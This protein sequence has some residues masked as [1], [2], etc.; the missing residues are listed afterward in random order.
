MPLTTDRTLSVF[1]LTALVPLSV[2]AS[3]QVPSTRAQWQLVAD[4]P[5][6]GKAA[7]F[8][9]QSFDPTT[10]RLW[11]AHM[12]A[13]EVLGFDVRT[14][15]VVARVPGMAGVTG[16]RVVPPVQRVF[17]A[18]SAG[19][20]VAILDSRDGRELARVPGGR[21]PDGLAYAPAAKKLFVSDEAGRQELV[22]DVPAARARPPIQLGG[23]A[24]NTQYDSVTG[25]IWVAVQTR[26]ELAAI[27]PL[28]DSVVE[29]IPVLGIEHP[30]GFCLDSEHRLIYVTGEENATL[31][32]LDLAEKRMLQTYPV[33]DDPDVLALDPV[34]RR[35][36][37]A[38]ESGVIAP[39]DVRGKTLVPLPQYRA[40]HAHSVG[41][42]PTTGLIYVPLENVAGRPVLR[43]LKL[44]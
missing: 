41:S 8:D 36:Y 23:E 34:R 27:D 30:H 40:S 10:N 22:I 9:Y 39:F 43:I 15:K 32:V 25:R 20:A 42:D 26:N 16:V 12:G 44:E 2:R 11:I 19:H 21:F 13:G 1:F 4:V 5:L 3:A 33:G 38:A 17:A 28:T 7:R 35:L 6:P 29:R 24:G 14:R 18:L 31:G 37:V